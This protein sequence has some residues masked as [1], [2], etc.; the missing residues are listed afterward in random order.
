MVP[1]HWLNSAA[2]APLCRDLRSDVCDCGGAEERV[3]ACAAVVAELRTPV[4]LVLTAFAAAAAVAG[5]I[6][7]VHASFARC[8]GK[9][10]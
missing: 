4:V 3:P 5:G 2:G 7:A 9:R 10:V 1:V 8:G 6:V